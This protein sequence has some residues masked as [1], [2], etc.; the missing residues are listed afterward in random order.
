LSRTYAKIISHVA[1]FANGSPHSPS[2]LDLAMSSCD[3]FNCALGIMMMIMV[4][5]LSKLSTA[6]HLPI[7]AYTPE[8]N[9][10]DFF[11]ANARNNPDIFLALLFP[12]CN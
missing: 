12:L 8:N 5:A 3:D 2:K 9:I 4:V 11:Y 6:L 10:G 7:L 1:T